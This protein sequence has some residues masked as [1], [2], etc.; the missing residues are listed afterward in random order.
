MPQGVS[1]FQA[2]KNAAT[3]KRM[4]EAQATV[5]IPLLIQRD[6]WLRQCVVSALKQSVPC[7]VLV[8]TSP[9]TPASNLKIL[10]ELEATHPNLAILGEPPNG[11]FP[12]ALNLG[13]RSASADRVGFLLAD[14]WLDETAV[15]ECLRHSSD[16]VSTRNTLYAADGETVVEERRTVNADYESLPTLEAKASYLRHLFVF[17]KPK[18][19]EVG[20]VDESVGLTGPDD[21][22][23]IWTLLEQGATVTI[24]EKSLY[25]KRDHDEERLTLR[26]REAQTRDLERILDKHGVTGCER[27]A[28][29]ERHSKWY[30]ATAQATHAGLGSKGPGK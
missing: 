1:G 28:I 13:I 23:L 15:S 10:S 5:V 16:I 24:V 17:R 8:V 7:E 11:G 14:D 25:S 9:R 20:G 12:G 26:S 27:R 21:F 22:D 19:L 4:Q 18:L 30:G 29:I 2:E 3:R 6:E